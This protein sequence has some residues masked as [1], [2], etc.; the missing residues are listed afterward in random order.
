MEVGHLKT[1][2]LSL[3]VALVGYVVGL[4]GGMGLANLFWFFKSCRRH[5]YI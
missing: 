3:L 5:H 1:L 4:I 2:G